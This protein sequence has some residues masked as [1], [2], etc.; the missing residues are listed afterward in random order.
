MAGPQHRTPEYRAAYTK[1]S[2]AHRRRDLVCVQPVC[3]VEAEGG[4]R[5]IPR[6]RPGMPSGMDV[7]H[8]DSGMV[9]LGPAH[10]RCN[11]GDGGRRRHRVTPRRWV[12]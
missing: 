1:L 12:L 11:R 7:A 9:I 10:R 5:V 2:R 8:D 6:R 4:S 3:V